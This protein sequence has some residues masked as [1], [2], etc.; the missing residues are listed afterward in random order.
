MLVILRDV[1][2]FG[3][4]R[5]KDLLETDERISTNVLTN[6]L[7]KLE[8][9]GLITS[10]LYNEHPPRLEY[11]PT[12]AA[13]AM[14]PAIEALATWGKEYLSDVSTETLEFKRRRGR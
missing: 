8:A 4:V 7:K 12:P 3:K 11:K 1:L 14:L 6:R 5:F 10:S 13:W 9:S 2:R